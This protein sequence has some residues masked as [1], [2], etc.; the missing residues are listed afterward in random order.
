MMMNPIVETPEV[1]EALSDISPDNGYEVIDGQLVE[2]PM[3]AESSM[4]AMTLVGHLQPFASSRKLGLVFGPDCGYQFQKND[5]KKVRKPDVSF[6]AQGRL[7]GD[8]PPRGNITVAPDLAVEVV[9]PNDLVDDLD[10]RIEEY[11]SSNTRLLWIVFPLTA[12][13]LVLRQDG[14]GVRL[15]GGQS[16]S[17]ED[18]LPEFTCPVQAL[19]ADVSPAPAAGTQEAG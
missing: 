2:K 12:S 9:S 19:F 17:G 6:V 13:V 11:L 8:R 1:E 5:P 16:L 4:I 18:V 7:A 15:R 14:S 3:G 10:T